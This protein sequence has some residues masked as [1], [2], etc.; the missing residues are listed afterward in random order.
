APVAPPDP[1]L[2]PSSPTGGVPSESLVAL[3]LSK[4]RHEEAL[5]LIERRRQALSAPAPSGGCPFPSTESQS[6]LSLPLVAPEAITSALQRLKEPLVYFHVY[7]PIKTTPLLEGTVKGSSD[8]IY[9][10]AGAASSLL[11]K[12]TNSSCEDGVGD[13]AYYPATSDK[14]R[15]KLWKWMV[16]PHKEEVQFHEADFDGDNPLETDLNEIREALGISGDSSTLYKRY[17]SDIVRWGPRYR[18]QWLSQDGK[19]LISCS[20]GEE[21]EAEGGSEGGPSSLP[22]NSAFRRAHPLSSSN[23]SLSSLF[24]L[25]SATSSR[26]RR[27]TRS[28]LSRSSAWANWEGPPSLAR[29]YNLLMEPFDLPCCPR[30]LLVLDSALRSVPF[31]LLRGPDGFLALNYCIV[32]QPGIS[33]CPRNRVASGDLRPLVVDSRSNGPEGQLVAEILGAE[34]PL[35]GAEAEKTA[36]LSALPRSEVAHLSL[37]LNTT[38]TALIAGDGKGEIKAT[39]LAGTKTPLFAML[40]WTQ[41]SAS[42]D[43][44]LVTADKVL[45]LAQSMVQSG[46][47][48]CVA[49]PLWPV[50]DTPKKIFFRSFYT[51]LIQ[52]AAVSAALNEAQLTVSHSKHLGHLVH[53]GGWVVV[54]RSDVRLPTPWMTLGASLAALLNAPAQC[55]DALRVCLHLVEKSLQRLSRPNAKAMYTTLASIER[56]VGTAAEGWRD[57]LMSVGFRFEPP[58]GSLPASVFFPQSNPGN[59]LGVASEALQGLCG[60]PNPVLAAL[61]RI[62]MTGARSEEVKSLLRQLVQAE[63]SASSWEVPVSVWSVAGC[64]EL[65]SALG[66]DLQDVG[67]DQ[68]R[69]GLSGLDQRHLSFAASALDTLVESDDEGPLSTGAPTDWEGSVAG[70]KEGLGSD[71]GSSCGFD[72]GMPGGFYLPPPSVQGG[73]DDDAKGMV[74]GIG[75]AFSR[76]A[77][78]RKQRGEPDGGSAPKPEPDPRP[79]PSF[80]PS[81]T[82]PF[83]PPAAVTPLKTP[84]PKFKGASTGASSGLG[85]VASLRDQ[86][87]ARQVNQL[88]PSSPPSHSRPRL[89]PSH[90]HFHPLSPAPPLSSILM[91]EEN[92]Q[93]T[94]RDLGDGCYG[95]AAAASRPSPR[96]GKGAVAT[97]ATTSFSAHF[98]TTQDSTGRLNL[99]QT[100]EIESYIQQVFNNRH[101]GGGSTRVFQAKF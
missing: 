77:I 10:N 99:E 27:S 89:R 42:S 51:S 8:T 29:L 63:Q 36:V 4:G 91:D 2:T 40:S 59:R 46:G 25:G 73:S 66:M 65:L 62:A 78:V 19:L 5:V 98:I 32:I 60:L 86:L 13:D 79:I 30:L 14:K 3:L 16:L 49:L 71:G 68:V 57:L 74:S 83:K 94:G 48:A 70:D 50:G 93:P 100:Q 67:Q 97:T 95:G 64:H 84:G 58:S 80:T 20:S 45:S 31:S 34:A 41:S 21:E 11:E 17:I 81:P 69:L 54:G 87:L 37:G 92:S 43:N 38:G 1:L 22:V 44:P 96:T 72:G 56:K 47:V 26:S 12:S 33:L 18:P 6:G 90:Q 9:E 28:N 88:S 55:R 61:G 35:V 39:D 75:G 52:G 85:V 7:N 101:P 53:W 82:S 15:T 23:H 24:S 76:L